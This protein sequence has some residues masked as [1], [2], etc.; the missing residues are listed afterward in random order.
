MKV[1]QTQRPVSNPITPRTALG[2][3]LFNLLINEL[4]EGTECTLSKFADSTKLGRV[5]DTPE[6]C[7]AIQRDLDWLV[8][9]V[10]NLMKFKGST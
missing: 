9:W 5:A 7:A 3:V 4:D 8:S 10:K 2:P 1:Y 6:G